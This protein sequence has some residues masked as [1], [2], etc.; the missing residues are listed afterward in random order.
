MADPILDNLHLFVNNDHR[1]DRPY[2]FGYGRA[3]TDKQVISPKQQ[4]ELCLKW[5]RD[6]KAAG[7]LPA[8]MEWAGWYCDPNESTRKPW[9]QRPQGEAVWRFL[10]PG[11][12]VVVARMDRAMRSTK[13]VC[14]VLEKFK[15]RNV[16]LHLLDFPIDLATDVGMFF[17]Q[18]LGAVGQ[19]ERAMIATRTKESLAWKRRQGLPYGGGTPIGWKKIDKGAK[20]RFIVNPEERQQCEYIVQL[21]DRDKLSY[22]RVYYKLLRSVR[23]T[24]GKEWSKGAIERAYHA[25]KAGFPLKGCENGRD[26]LPTVAPRE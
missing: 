9:V 15:A 4:E 5:F 19:L 23:R 21:L 13:E 26:K 8:N 14:E 1:E 10:R 24:T 2:L 25:A 12:H 6:S 18:I 11:D 20:S 3:S 7:K 22:M 17:A 16:R